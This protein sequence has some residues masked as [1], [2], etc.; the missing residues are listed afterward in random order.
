[1]SMSKNSAPVSIE[2]SGFNAGVVGSIE[3]FETVLKFTAW[4][5]PLHIPAC[6]MHTLRAPGPAPR[7]VS[8]DEMAATTPGFRCEVAHLVDV[9]EQR[10][11]FD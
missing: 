11:C 9:Q 8:K 4:S 10:P 5:R 7:P 2:G 6:L 3:S 1:L